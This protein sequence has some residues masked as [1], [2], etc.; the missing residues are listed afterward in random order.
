MT[1]RMGAAT[2]RARGWCYFFG[3]VALPV[4]WVLMVRGLIVY[5]RSLRSGL[6]PV[7][8]S[9]LLDALW[10][11]LVGIGG[12]Q[13]SCASVL[14]MRCGIS[15]GMAVRFSLRWAMGSAGADSPPAVRRARWWALSGASWYRGA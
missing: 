10:R 9:V 3:L 1:M 7:Y 15:T 11:G 6:L 13:G 4:Y 12:G 5:Q 8:V 2:A 14:A